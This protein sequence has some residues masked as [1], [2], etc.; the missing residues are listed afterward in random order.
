MIVHLIHA[1]T[2]ISTTIL[3]HLKLVSHCLLLSNIVKLVS[4][5]KYKYKEKKFRSIL[6]LTTSI[7]GL[8]MAS[9]MSQR[10][11]LTQEWSKL[12]HLALIYAI[13]HF[14]VKMAEN[15]L[16]NGDTVTCNQSSKK[17]QS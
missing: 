4:I 9:E 15:S 2:S 11:V 5:W 16:C 10:H 13:K 17:M 6:A 12:D 14:W 1:Y 8:Q 7:S 3:H